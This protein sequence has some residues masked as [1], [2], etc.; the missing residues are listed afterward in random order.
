MHIRTFKAA[1]TREINRAS[2]LTGISIWQ[3][4]Y[5]E[6]IIRNDGELAASRQYIAQNPLRWGSGHDAENPDMPP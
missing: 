1:V 6:H 4:N 5:H 2:N 3:R